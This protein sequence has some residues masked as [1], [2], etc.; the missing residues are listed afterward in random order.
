MQSPRHLLNKVK[1]MLKKL[2]SPLGAMILILLIGL[3]TAF[4]MSAKPIE[5]PINQSP[6]AE[7]FATNLP[8]ENGELQALSQWKGKII[9]L[10]F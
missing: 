7:L 8:D 1:T 4:F 9:V 6:T 10:N 5:Q 3:A 2:V